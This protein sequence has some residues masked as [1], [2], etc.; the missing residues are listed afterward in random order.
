MG[1]TKILTVTG[2]GGGVVLATARGGGGGGG[3]RLV[4]MHPGRSE[5]DGNNR[6]A[7]Q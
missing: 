3:S 4:C 1:D 5:R 2:A 7:E 6:E